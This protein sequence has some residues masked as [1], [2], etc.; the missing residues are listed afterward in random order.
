MATTFSTCG[1]AALL[2]VAP[3]AAPAQGATWSID[4]DAGQAI[5]SAVEAA[6][7]GD[8][9]LVRGLCVE[10]VR[11]LDEVTRITL[12][13]QGLTTLRSPSR[14]SNA[15]LVAG[16]SI[17][18]R[19]FTI[20]GGRNGV[21]VLRGGTALID[22]TAIRDNA[23]NGINVAQ[24]SYARVVNSV[25][26]FNATAGIRVL[27]SSFVRAGFLDL[28]TATPAGNLIRRN[29]PAGGVLVARTSGASLVGNTIS[30]NDGPG[31]SISGASHADL[32]G[33]FVDGN[34]SDGVVVTQQSFVQL[35]DLQGILNP[36][37]ETAVGNVGFGVVCSINSAVDGLIGTLAGTAGTRRFDSSCANGAKIK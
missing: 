30:D 7:P 22:R 2:L 4:C 20:T 13:G 25:I 36:P 24:H 37:N 29:G 11:I 1:L 5:Q 31:V 27:E 32:A 21:A 35:G 14:T 6:Q 12:D 33:N 34:G 9:I 19:R 10:S 16:R 8:T 28:E 15:L 18:I 3:L 23:D 17:T 26:E